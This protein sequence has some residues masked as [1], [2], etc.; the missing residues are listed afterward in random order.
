MNPAFAIIVV[1]CCIALW[2]LASGI[3]KLIGKFVYKIGKDAMDELM[4][5]DED[6]LNNKKA[7]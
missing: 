7:R 5:T 3:Y 4:D 6:I 1:L 2:F